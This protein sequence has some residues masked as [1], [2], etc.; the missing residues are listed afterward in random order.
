[1]NSP[2]NKKNHDD[3][4]EKENVDFAAI[5]TGREEVPEV[6]TLDTALA[7]FQS[8]KKDDDDDNNNKKNDLKFSVKTTDMSKIKE[9]HIYTG[10]PSEKGDVVAD[11][12]KSETPSGEVIMDN[13][14]EG[15]IKSKDLKGPLEGKSTQELVRKM[16]KG[17]AYVDISTADKPKGKVRGKIKKLAPPSEK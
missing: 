10:K 11:L 3:K 17:E 9:V 6:D 13:I 12:Y 2:T 5:L 16:E 15:K 1:M 8:N 7:T 4:E 14:S